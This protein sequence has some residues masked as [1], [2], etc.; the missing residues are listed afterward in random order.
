[1]SRCNCHECIERRNTDG[2]CGREGCGDSLAGNDEWCGLHTAM[3]EL[4]MDVD[5][6]DRAAQSAGV[7]LAF[8]VREAMAKVCDGLETA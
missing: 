3:I 8:L 5:R 1:M 4:G 6:Y 7:S 2:K